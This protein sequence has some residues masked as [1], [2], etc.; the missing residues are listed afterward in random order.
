MAINVGVLVNQTIIIFHTKGK[1]IDI[2]NEL[3]VS[4]NNEVGKINYPYRIHN[5]ETV[6]ANYPSMRADKALG[7]YRDETLSFNKHISYIC[8]KQL[9]SFLKKLSMPS[10]LY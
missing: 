10:L 8:A 9:A 1:H 2:G 5:V 4:N 3:L 6:F 7:I